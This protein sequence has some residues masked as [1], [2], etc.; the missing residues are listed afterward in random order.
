MRRGVLLL[1]VPAVALASC[2]NPTAR[3]IADEFRAANSVK[4]LALPSGKHLATISDPADLAALA[5][6]AALGSQKVPCKCPPTLRLI[7]TRRDGSTGCAYADIHRTDGQVHRGWVNCD[8]IGTIY[9]PALF[10]DVME[11]YVKP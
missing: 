6:A 7:L 5:D 8:G 11:R 1:A 2:G 10:W 9:P 4:I 3:R